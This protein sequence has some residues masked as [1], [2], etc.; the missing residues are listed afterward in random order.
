MDDDR[1]MAVYVY[2]YGG[3]KPKAMTDAW[4]HPWFGLTATPR[5]SCILSPKTSACTAT[6]TIRAW[7]DQR[8]CR[9]SDTT[10]STRESVTWPW[11]RERYRRRNASTTRCFV[12]WPRSVA[13]SCDKRAPQPCPSPSRTWVRNESVPS[14]ARKVMAGEYEPGDEATENQAD[15]DERDHHSSD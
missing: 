11:P 10:T 3:Q 8:C 6:S 9:S 5:K 4:P 2:M 13:S 7:P 15:H 1:H 12:N 14:G